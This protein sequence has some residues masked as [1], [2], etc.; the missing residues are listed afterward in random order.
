MKSVNL[1]N[2]LLLG[3]GGTGKTSIAEALLYTS[4]AIDRMGKIPDGNTT[5]DY[6]PEEIKRQYS[7]SLAF[8][9]VDL[10]ESAAIDEWSFDIGV[11][12]KYL[13]QDGVIKL[14]EAGGI[15]FEENMTPAE[16]LTMM[17]N[18]IGEKSALQDVLSF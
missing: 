5:L 17:Q 3:H 9:P 16:K 6:D 13:S 14:A 12:C 18:L 15:K 1:R 2:V 10:N 4:K 7:I 11:A 8:A